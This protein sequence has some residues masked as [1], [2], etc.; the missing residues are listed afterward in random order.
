MYFWKLKDNYLI[1]FHLQKF[2]GTEPIEE[3]IEQVKTVKIED[4]PSKDVKTELVDEVLVR[5]PYFSHY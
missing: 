3:V 4:D 5:H 1:F 2:K